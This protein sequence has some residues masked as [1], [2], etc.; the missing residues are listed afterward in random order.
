MATTENPVKPTEQQNL[1]TQ[2]TKPLA[3]DPNVKHPLRIP[4]TL[5]YEYHLTQNTRPSS[6]NWGE[7][8][9]QVYTFQS[10]EDFWRLYN[11]VTPPS[12]LQLG[13][14]YNLFKKGIEPKWE[15]P[16]NAKGGKWTLIISKTK[17]VLDRLWLWMLLACVG[18]ALED[19]DQICGAVVNVRRGQDK[20]CIWTRDA[21]NKDACMKIGQMLKKVLELPDVFPISYQPHFAKDKGKA[22]QYQI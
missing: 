8:I 20:L 12:Q 6:N 13:C 18:E 4:W 2:L 10:V 19:E 9:K 15:D 21:D 17:G 16:S 14:S 5:W 11:N 22:N 3:W 1:P 7:N